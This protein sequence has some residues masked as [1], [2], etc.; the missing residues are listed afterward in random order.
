MNTTT[1]TTRV[2]FYMEGKDVLAVFPDIQEKNRYRDDL[3][4]CYSHVG[5]HSTCEPE[6]IKRKRLASPEEYKDLLNELRGIYPDLEVSHIKKSKNA[7][8][9]LVEVQYVSNAGN[10]L[11]VSKVVKADDPH[12]AILSVQRRIESKGNCM[13]INGG[14]AELIDNK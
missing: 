2:K 5:Q 6:Y 10:P 14:H 8:T 11:A 12:Q 1:A 13:K 7:A 3:L 4:L 9:Y